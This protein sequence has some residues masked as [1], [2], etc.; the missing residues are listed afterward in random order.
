MDEKANINDNPPTIAD[1]LGVPPARESSGRSVL[2][3]S[4][5]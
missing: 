4:K 5:K 1:F 3:F 2:G